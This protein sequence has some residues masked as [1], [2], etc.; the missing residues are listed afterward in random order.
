MPT[1]YSYRKNNSKVPLE[2]K[3]YKILLEHS[4]WEDFCKQSDNFF[5]GMAAQV[6]IC[7]MSAYGIV[8]IDFKTKYVF[9]IVMLSMFIPW[10]AIFVLKTI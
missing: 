10:E 1:I 4:Q 2:I 7:S 5:L 3:N 9:A 8:F 6:I